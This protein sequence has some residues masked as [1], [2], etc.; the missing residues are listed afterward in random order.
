MKDT[1]QSRLVCR[2]LEP[3]LQCLL[4]RNED[5]SVNSND[6]YLHPYYDER[7]CKISTETKTMLL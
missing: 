5:H 4:D 3:S 7:S 1:L 2:L 6:A